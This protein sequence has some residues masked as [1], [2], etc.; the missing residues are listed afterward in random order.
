M[1]RIGRAHVDAV[2]RDGWANEPSGRGLA[3]L[4]IVGKMKEQALRRGWRGCGLRLRK[5]G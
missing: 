5:V 4:G 1:E 2:H 3:L